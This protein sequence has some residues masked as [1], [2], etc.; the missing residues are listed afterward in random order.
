M[1][2]SLREWP[3]VVFSL[4]IAI[5][6]I[7][8]S[9]TAFAD[10]RMCVDL[11]GFSGNRFDLELGATV[12]RNVGA[13][14]VGN[15]VAKMSALRVAAVQYPLGENAAPA[16]FL[17]K[18]SG[19][20]SE[21]KANRADLVV[22]PELL[23]TELVNWASPEGEVSQLRSIARDFTPSYFDWLKVQALEKNV[24]ILGGSTPR[25]V[26]EKI[27]NTAVLAF[28]NGRLVLQDK[29]FLTPDEKVW[30]WTPGERLEVFDAP[31]GKS[32]IAICFDCEF[33]LLSQGLVA[34]APEVILVPSWT[35]TTYGRN[36]VD[37]TA[38]ARAIE[39]YAY[40][41]K[42]GTVPDP[43]SSQPHYGQATIVTPQDVG[44]KD[45][46]VQGSENKQEIVYAELDMS[47]LREGRARSGYFP[48]KEQSTRSAPVEII[49]NETSSQNDGG[50]P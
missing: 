5:A 31:W 45:S 48:G 27:V 43:S 49:R 22:L 12:G 21:A 23:T 40:V 20:V 11:F 14:V 44:F 41:V 26:G 7:F 42:T 9:N 19:F 4:G 3:G 37:W 6:T 16:A 47:L 39:H 17:A 2:L 50:R 10:R 18:V 24:A 36:R 13:S 30:G 1:E 8:L 38:R 25:L 46:V 32:V 35:S 28:P 34:S 29:I 15:R 33:P